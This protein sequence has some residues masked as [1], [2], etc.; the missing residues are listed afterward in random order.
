MFLNKII[1][2]SFFIIQIVNGQYNN[3]DQFI[4]FQNKFSKT[5]KSNSEMIIRSKIFEYNLNNINHHNSNS[6]FNYKL[7]INQFSDLL[8]HEINSNKLITDINDDK[9]TEFIDYILEFNKKYDNSDDFYDR[10]YYFK[11]NLMII[12]QHNSD[13]RSFKLNLNQYSDESS[14]EFDSRKGFINDAL[15]HVSSK[16]FKMLTKDHVSCTPF[17][18]T[19]DEQLPD[20]IDWRDHNAVTPVKNQEKCGSCWSFSTTGAIEGAWSIK[21]DKLVS[22]SEQQLIDCSRSYG[23]L[24][25]YGGLMDN[26]FSYAIENGMCTEDEYPYTAHGHLCHSCNKSIHIQGCV[27]IDQGNQLQLKKAVSLG[28]VSVAIE[29]DKSIFQ[30]YSQGVIDTEECGENLDHGVLIV[31]YGIENDLPYW[32]VKNSWGDSWGDEGYVKI[33]R[34][35]NSDDNGV[36]GIAMQASYV[37]A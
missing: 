29:A 20:S 25:C 27:D 6:E 37:L 22:I 13:I 9:L 11:Q 23:D 18:Q 19:Y 5:Y 7:D 36:C 2:L 26:A 24:G 16:I 34:S 35:E 28:P 14:D 33:L 12:N 17:N 1:S 8:P 3:L 21:H 15:Y 10:F 30:S 31:G 4:F 32:L